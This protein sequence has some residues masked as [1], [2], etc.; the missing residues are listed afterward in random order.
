MNS[1]ICTDGSKVTQAQI[2]RKM[3]VAKEKLIN[4]QR[5]SFGYNFC[6]K[7][8]RSSGVRFDCSHIVS[9]KQAK[10]LSATQKCWDVNNMRVLCRPCHQKFDGLDLKFT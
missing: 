3:R 2:E 9:I 7:C 10:E 1:Y 6:V 8:K 5:E 4:N